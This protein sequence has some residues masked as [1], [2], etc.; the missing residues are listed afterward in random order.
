MCCLLDLRKTIL[1]LFPGSSC[2]ADIPLNSNEIA[3]GL[4]SADIEW[5]CSDGNNAGSVCTK[6]C[7]YGF[8]LHGSRNTKKEL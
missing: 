5:D 4:T 3:A 2:P 8:I 6:T 1:N 7:P